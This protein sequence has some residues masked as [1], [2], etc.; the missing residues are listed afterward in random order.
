MKLDNPKSPKK[1]VKRRRK[2]FMSKKKNKRGRRRATSWCHLKPTLS[3]SVSLLKNKTKEERKRKNKK[4]GWRFGWM[5]ISRCTMGARVCRRAT[6]T[7][8]LG[9]LLLSQSRIHRGTCTQHQPMCRLFGRR[10]KMCIKNIKGLLLRH[11]LI[12]T[13]CLDIF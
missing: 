5:P 2:S 4:G 3:L 13:T 6:H 12:S 8:C 9:P 7:S 1:K 10:V 11:T